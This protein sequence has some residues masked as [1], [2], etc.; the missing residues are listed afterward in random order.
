MTRLGWLASVATIVACLGSGVAS[1]AAAPVV[2][3]G[4]TPGAPTITLSVVTASGADVGDTYLPEV[5]VAAD[6]TVTGTPVTL[7]VNG[8]PN[9][10]ISLLPA[11][12]AW[13]G[14]CTNVN[15]AVV[16][17]V[18]SD[19]NA[20]GTP[21]PDFVLAGNV[22]TPL[23][24][25]GT[26]A[27]RVSDGV[28]SWDFTLPRDANG[29]GIADSFERSFGGNLALDG[30]SDVDGHSNF[31][32]YRGFIVSTRLIRGNPT[33]KDLFVFLVNPQTAGS[34]SLPAGGSLLG[35]LPTENRRVYPIDGTSLTANI[36]DLGDVAQVH[37]LGQRRDAL[38]ALVFDGTNRNTR[39]MVD[40]LASFSVVAGRET[41]VYRTS[42]APTP[43]ITIDNLN[44]SSTPA[45]D[46]VVNRN[47]RFGVPQK[48]VRIIESLDV[49]KSTPIGSATWGTP[50]GLDEAVIYTQRIVNYIL[51]TAPTSETRLHYATH[52]GSTWGAYT[53]QFTVG[54]TALPID[55]HYIISKMMQ[56]VFAHE[57]GGHDTRLTVTATTLGFHDAT[58]T[59]GMLDSQVQIIT[60][61][62]PTGIKFRI[63]SLFLSGHLSGV[64]VAP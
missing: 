42:D 59:G 20:D 58:G 32:E 21:R 41:W 13:P 25:G 31:D 61:G 22:L 11:T 8:A 36:D 12:T 5:T 3:I 50:N 37:L 54:G 40:R 1:V 30:D 52:D 16:N 23:D 43:T 49:S 24:C 64:Q 33:K 38:G 44:R 55:R 26:A 19:T 17:G 48:A 57:A 60:K 63:P 6:G 35:K 39:E 4:A 9:A 15:A 28:N 62:S 29:N 18:S 2:P 14:T 7:V 34:L 10:T 47:R 27:L 46:R 56:W 45:D 53:N 51:N